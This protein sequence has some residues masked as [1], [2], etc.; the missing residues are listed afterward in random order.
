MKISVV[1][2]GYVGLVSG[3]CFA[4]V[5]HDV[6]CVDN[7]YT[8]VNKINNGESP[9]YEEGLSELLKKHININ[10]RATTDLSKAILN[11]E[12]TIIAV[13]TPFGKD[14]IDLQYIEKVS[15]EIGQVL[16][17]KPSY[18]VVV[19]K[20]TVVPG[21]TDEL[22]LPLL[23]KYSCKKAG[24]DFGVGMNPEFLREGSAITDFMS[25]DRIVIGGIDKKTQN[26]L[27]DIYKPFSETDK[28]KT[29]NKT[30][31]MI[32]YTSN[33]LL[34]TLISFS[35]EIG[36]LCSLQG[37]MDA[38]EVMKGVHLDK[39]ISPILKNNQRISPSIIS[40]LEAGCGFG[41][42]CFP[43]DVRALISY[44]K[45]AGDKMQLLSSVV[46]INN[47]QPMKMLSLLTKHF[48]NLDGKRIAILGLAFKPG[49]DDMRES[50]AIPII[51]YLLSKNTKI[52]AYDPVAQDEAKKIFNT[53]KITYCESIRESTRDVDAVLLLTR[54]QE[55][56]TLPKILNKY[57]N[58]PLLIDGRRMFPKNCLPRYEGIGI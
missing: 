15:K 35:N 14:T 18:H 7:D 27:N 39:R 40:Y 34:A 49:T 52:K 2:T 26:K 19:V 30:A 45:N 37:D 53:T 12:L 41:G 23:E 20:S 9:I 51:K 36:N 28:L 3:V 11:T 58:P 42:S 31:E 10:L 50:P 44:G 55:F 5:G 16:K 13:G 54:W 38:I 1:G 25:P 56:E 22:V 8:K 6:I 29:N 43:K 57:I 47:D 33:S 4:E 46:D 48:P 32:K 17:N 21:T 24:K